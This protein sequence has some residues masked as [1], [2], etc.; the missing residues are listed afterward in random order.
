M[1]NPRSTSSF[2]HECIL[3][4]SYVYNMHQ[5][6]KS[7]RLIAVCKRTLM[8]VSIRIFKNIYMVF[9][10]PSRPHR[11]SWLFQKVIP[12]HHYNQEDRITF[13][14]SANPLFYKKISIKYL[15]S[16][17]MTKASAMLKWGSLFRRFSIFRDKS[18]HR[19][20]LPDIFPEKRTF[21]NYVYIAKNVI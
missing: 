14:R 18:F 16:N 15:N 9:P 20:F 3:L 13:I 19:I 17:E 21:W 5:D 11:V 2:S 10:I 12:H 6:T 8:L 4:P 7:A 1:V